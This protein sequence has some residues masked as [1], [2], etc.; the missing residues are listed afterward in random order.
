MVVM[1]MV[2]V[3]V[4]VMVVMVMVVVVVVVMV[5]MVVMVVVMVVVVVV[6]VEVVILRCHIVAPLDPLKYCAGAVVAVVAGQV[7]A[8]A[9]NAF[10]VPLCVSNSSSS[11]APCSPTH[12]VPWTECSGGVPLAPFNL[13]ILCCAVAAAVIAF[14]WTENTGSSSSSSSSSSRQGGQLMTAVA[15]AHFL[16]SPP[17][18][19][20]SCAASP[21]PPPCGSSASCSRC[22]RAACAP[23][24]VIHCKY[25]TL[26]ACTC[27]SRCGSTSSPPPPPP[28][29][30]PSTQATCSPPSWPHAGPCPPTIITARA[31]Q[32]H[33]VLLTPSHPAAASAAHSMLWPATVSPL[34]A[35]S[36]PSR[37]ACL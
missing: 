37:R 21:P 3:V 10:D 36:C 31:A 12:T 29:P 17:L 26:C 24:S 9:H 11:T 4:V 28:L 25:V 5:V 22:S 1:V 23:A 35:L 20:D 2:V 13:V 6:V 27:L 7:A 16:C 8:A 32:Y 19:R 34:P 15:C 14:T 30:S 18:T 33:L